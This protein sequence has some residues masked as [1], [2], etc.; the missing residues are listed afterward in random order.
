MINKFGGNEIKGNL[1][2]ITFTSCYCHITYLW[3]ELIFFIL[4]SR[5]G[6]KGFH[7][8]NKVAIHLWI[9]RVRYE[10]WETNADIYVYTD[11]RIYGYTKRQISCSNSSV[12]SFRYKTISPRSFY[13]QPRPRPVRKWKEGVVKGIIRCPSVPGRKD[14]PVWVEMS[15]IC[16]CI[17]CEGP[18]GSACA[19]R[20]AWGPAGSNRS[21][22]PKMLSRD[23]GNLY[24][25]SVLEQKAS[26]CSFLAPDMRTQ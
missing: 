6:L 2:I 10:Y 20:Q 19:Q 11:I 12:W 25:H 3:E 26:T 23:T 5:L 22:N 7:F 4:V 17:S 13:I 18:A 8:S 24:V 15:Q 9:N 16:E 21:Y 14:T 1:G